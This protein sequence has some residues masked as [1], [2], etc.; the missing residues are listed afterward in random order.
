MMSVQNLNLNYSTFIQFIIKF[1]LKY[2]I[3]KEKELQINKQFQIDQNLQTQE[4]DY[5][6]TLN[7]EI[8]NFSS[9][10]CQII[11]Y[12]KQIIEQKKYYLIKNQQIKI[13]KCDA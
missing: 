5:T 1:I 6:K 8:S 7:I 2:L 13:L 12:P 4:S 3:K 9:Q 11:D 10:T